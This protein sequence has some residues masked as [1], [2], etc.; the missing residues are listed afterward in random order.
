MVILDTAPDGFS[1]LTIADVRHVVMVTMEIERPDGRYLAARVDG[2]RYRIWVRDGRSHQ[3]LAYL[4]LADEHI[5]ARRAVA[6]LFHEHIT[7]G[8]CGR[9]PPCL[10]PGKSERW[11]LTQFLRLLD[12]LDE[13]ASARELA[14]TLIAA[15][16]RGFSASEWDAS[17]ERKRISRWTDKAVA[18]R[19][20]RFRDLLL[21]R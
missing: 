9:P 3:A 10:H 5:G 21:G 20:G 15:D 19:D 11:R 18:M 16:A 14:A 4:I 7:A 8:G 2:T 1:T 12:A 6:T 13:G 17:R